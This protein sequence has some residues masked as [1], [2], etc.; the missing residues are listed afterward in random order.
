V[1]SAG[2]DSIC[3]IGW[4]RSPVRVIVESAGADSILR[5]WLAPITRAHAGER[6]GHDLP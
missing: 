3:V 2:A 1:E 6:S 4:R 5:D